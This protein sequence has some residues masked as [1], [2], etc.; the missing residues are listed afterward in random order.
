M[1]LLTALVGLSI[2][3]TACSNQEETPEIE[4]QP[5]QEQVSEDE[6]ELDETEEEN[7]ETED[8]EPGEIEDEEDSND[9]ASET[10]DEEEEKTELSEEEQL[11]EAIPADASVDDWN[12]IL[13]NPWQALPEGFTPNITEVDNQQRIDT[14]IVDAWY[15]WK[16]A[17]LSAGHRLFFASG[18]RNVELQRTNF[19]NTYQSYIDQGYSEEEALSMTKDYLTE[20]GHSEHHTGLALDIVDEEWIVAGR[21]LETAYETQ[22]SQQWLVD[23]MADYGFVLRYP[24]GKEDITGI[25]YEPWHFRYVGPENATFMV[26]NH[27]V[28]EEYIE[29]LNKRDQAE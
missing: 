28:L 5:D 19:N 11:I 26:N 29:L 4:N 13:V 10:P 3:L 14:R 8:Q 17:A 24:L 25:Q 2:V 15:A 20:P 27:L 9:S 6:H 12:L 18:Y 22:S 21:G 23:T 1:R 16:D 7:S